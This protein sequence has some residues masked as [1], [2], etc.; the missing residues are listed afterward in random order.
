MTAVVSVIA[1][2]LIG[3]LP[4]S[5]IFSRLRRGVD[6]RRHGTGNVGATNTLLVAGK[7]AAL[8]ALAGDIAKGVGAIVLARYLGLDDRGIALTAFAVV[9]GHD[10]PLFLGFKGGKGVAT[11]A[12]VLF[13]LDWIFGGLI[14]LLWVLCMTLV[15]YFI[16][17]SV[18]TFVLV[19]LVM[20]L[21]SWRWPYIIFGVANAALAI[22]AHRRD[23]ARFFAGQETPIQEALA[24]YFKK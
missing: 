4:F 15:R 11:T 2:Y 22:Y 3:S 7:L 10:F 17:G 19:P 14:V 21:G 20:W 13:G 1:A 16:P 9:V 24:K 23:L 5:Y 6:P 12:G 18:L 8:L